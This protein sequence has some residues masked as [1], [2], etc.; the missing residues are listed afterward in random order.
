[1]NIIL[2]SCWGSIVT[3]YRLDGLEIESWW[4]E[5]FCAVQTHPESHPAFCT[6]GNGS[7]LG[8]RGPEHGSDHPP[9]SSGRLLMGRSYT[10]TFPMGLHKHVMEWHMILICHYKCTLFAHNLL[11]KQY[12][13]LVFNINLKATREGPTAIRRAKQREW[14]YIVG[15]CYH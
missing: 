2:I 11:A 10:S 1:M 13:K 8:V 4:R 7:F 12:F 6:L 5:I 14:G 9:P 15:Q 3:H